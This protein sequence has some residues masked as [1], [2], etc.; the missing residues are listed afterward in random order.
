[1]KWSE[2]MCILFVLWSDERS[3]ELVEKNGMFPNE[4]QKAMSVN[5]NEHRHNI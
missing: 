1:M 5:R 3:H 4:L 2:Y